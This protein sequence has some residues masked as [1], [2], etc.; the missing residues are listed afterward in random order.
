MIKSCTVVNDDDLALRTSLSG[1]AEMSGP[2]DG[3]QP[4]RAHTL[5]PLPLAAVISLATATSSLGLRL[6]GIIGST[7]IRAAREGSLTGLELGRVIF[8]GILT[9]AG[10]DVSTTASG[11]LGRIC[12]D[13]LLLD[14]VSSICKDTSPGLLT[15]VLLAVYSSSFHYFYRFLGVRRLPDRVH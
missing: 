7:A 14:S 15:R 13:R 12:A 9:R 10:H 11:D 2:N 6:G 5:L 4:Q 3:R 1:S 8:E